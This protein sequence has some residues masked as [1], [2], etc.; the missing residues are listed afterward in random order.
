MIIKY[1]DKKAIIERTNKSTFVNSKGFNHILD[2]KTGLSLT[3]GNTKTEDPDFSPFGPL[4]ADIEV[5]TICHGPNNK[6][7]SFCYKSN[8]QN[9]SYMSFNTYK[10]VFDKLPL[11]VGQIAFGVDAT[12]TSNPDIWKIMEYTKENNVV[13]NLTV[14]DVSDEIA[15]RLSSLCGAVAVSRYDDKNLCYDSIKKLTDRGM[16]QVNIHICYFEENFDMV[17]ETINDIKR[18]PRL[19]KLN[20]VVFLALKQKGRGKNMTPISF[21]KFKKMVNICTDNNIRYGFDSCSCNKF[22]ELTKVDDRYDYE[23]MKLVSEP[24]ESSCFSLYVNV[25]GD[26]YPCSFAEG[27]GTWKE[28]ISV[29]KFDDFLNDIWYNKRTIDFRDNLI[30]NKRSCPIYKI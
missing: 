6:P 14:A 26:F 10:K 29:I 3:W 30:L 28:G 13:P 25:E 5:T 1:K 21:D 20:A 11:T 4:I 15:D 27:S 2:K 7:C 24:C 23:Q 8:N 19:E 17:L 18:D 12:C 16:E 22:L 9:G